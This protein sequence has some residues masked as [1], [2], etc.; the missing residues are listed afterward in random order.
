MRF[1]ADENIPRAIVQ[2]LRDSGADVVWVA[3]TMPGSR[4]ADLL[5]IVAVN[6]HVLLTFDKD[7]GELARAAKLPPTCGIILIR[8]PMPRPGDRGLALAAA[9][10]SRRDWEGHFSILEEDRLRMRRLA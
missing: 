6:G 10:L 3:D 5:R 2:A 9:I 1:L 4:D 7:F 8:T